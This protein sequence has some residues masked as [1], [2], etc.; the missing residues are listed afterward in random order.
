M[1]G[2]GHSRTLPAKLPRSYWAAE[3]FVGSYAGGV[4]RF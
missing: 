2:S 3:W 1:L 4:A